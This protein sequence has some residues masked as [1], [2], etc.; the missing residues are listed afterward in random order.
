MEPTSTYT[1]YND[2]FELDPIA[3]GLTDAP[4]V[5]PDAEVPPPGFY[6]VQLT[7]A[8]LRLN[9]E[10][11]QPQYDSNQKRVFR[12]NRIQITDPELFAGSHALFQDIYVYG[13]PQMNWS[14]KPAVPYTDRPPVFQVVKLLSSIDTNLVTGSIDDNCDELERLLP[15]KPMVAVKLSYE[16]TDVTYAK[17][18]IAQGVDKNEAYKKS[19]LYTKHFRNTDGTYRQQTEGPSGLMI[20]ARL[21]I[22][23]FIPASR[24]STLTLG[25]MKAK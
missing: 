3:Y 2:Q 10:T 7:S 11:K 4:A 5:T 23:D 1:L 12:I 21:K 15:T 20:P 14:V 8:G 6:V 25:P 16:S 19:R 18:L 22:D 17:A 9:R 13:R 24:V